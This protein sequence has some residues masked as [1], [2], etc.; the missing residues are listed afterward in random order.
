M[1]YFEAGNLNRQLRRIVQVGA[2]AHGLLNVTAGDF[3]NLQ[4]Q[5]PEIDEQKKIAFLLN[6]CDHEIS[7]LQKQ[8]NAHRKQKRGLMQKL[9]TGEWLTK[10][11]GARK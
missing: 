11:L 2:R 8:L 9:L 7:L 4:L 10:P 3:F 1:H 5:I 6:N